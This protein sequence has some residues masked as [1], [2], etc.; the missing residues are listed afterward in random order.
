[1]KLLF[2][3]I[4]PKWRSSSAN[5]SSHGVSLSRRCSAHRGDRD[6]IS[7][8]AVTFPS[9]WRTIMPRWQ[10][11]RHFNRW[12]RCCD[13]WKALQ[14]ARCPWRAITTANVN[15]VIAIWKGLSSST[16]FPEVISAEKRRS[17]ARNFRN[18][19]RDRRAGKFLSN[20]PAEFRA[21][22]NLFFFFTLVF[23]TFHHLFVRKFHFFF[24]FYSFWFSF[25]FFFFSFLLFWWNV[26]RFDVFFSIKGNMEFFSF[27][28][29]RWIAFANFFPPFSF[30]LSSW[31]ASENPVS[32]RAPT[33]GNSSW[34]SPQFNISVLSTFVE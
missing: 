20:P 3:R 14:L 2:P 23:S 17:K 12:C 10:E 4:I 21:I 9:V 29:R 19:S 7:V 33:T 16:R 6:F 24:F 34:N 13:R 15:I 1:M 22:S 18:I 25:F 5:F 11:Q 30:S 26:G 27:D 28:D 8:L 32:L 31:N